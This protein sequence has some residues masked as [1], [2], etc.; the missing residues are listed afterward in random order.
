MVLTSGCKVFCAGLDITEMYQP[1]P[2]R[3]QVFWSSLQQL[4]ITTY[5]CKLPLTAAINGHR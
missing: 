2:A 5:G 3:L 1:D 4:W